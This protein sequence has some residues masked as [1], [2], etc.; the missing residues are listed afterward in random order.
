MSETPKKYK[1]EDYSMAVDFQDP[2]MLRVGECGFNLPWRA[3]FHDWYE[4]EPESECYPGRGNTMEEAIQNL[5]RNFDRY[6]QS[7]RKM[8]KPG[9]INEAFPPEHR[10]RY[11]AIYRIFVKFLGGNFFAMSLSDNNE[12]SRR[13]DQIFLP[14]EDQKQVFSIFE[15]VWK[16]DIQQAKTEKLKNLFKIISKKF[17]VYENSYVGL[18]WYPN[19]TVVG[20]YFTF[21]SSYLY[22]KLLG[23][24]RSFSDAWEAIQAIYTEF[25]SAHDQVFPRGR[26]L[27]DFEND[28]FVIIS[29]KEIISNPE[30]V[31]AIKKAFRIPTS[32][33]VKLETDPFYGPFPTDFIMSP[34]PVACREHKCSGH[35]VTI[36][37][38]GILE[39]T[40]TLMYPHINCREAHERV[41]R[42]NVPRKICY[43]RL[44]SDPSPDFLSDPR[45]VT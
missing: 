31:S 24:C 13:V 28:C 17:P 39:P 11:D 18:F 35:Q 16:I 4:Y 12:Y 25:T 41:C 22:D 45:K 20:N 7:G 9:I 33:S 10:N 36:V 40:S 42:P 34:E 29:T 27:F 14:G 38:S 32:Y 43:P 2:K 15:K 21:D 3:Y 5:R 26:V 37:E 8:P 19:Q 1:F 44:I 23:P 6:C 30:T